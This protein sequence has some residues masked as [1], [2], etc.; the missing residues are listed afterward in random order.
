MSLIRFAED[1]L[2][3]SGLL[4]VDSDYNG[5]AGKAVLE[6]VKTFSEQ[7][8]SGG[9]A[10]LVLSA[11]DKVARFE[12]L[13]PLTYARD[14]W[15]EVTDNIWQNKR[16]ATVFSTDEGKTWY[17]IDEEGRPLHPVE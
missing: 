2:Q 17:D 6:L 7:G 9:S 14:E 11:F 4:D 3:R 10:W 13:T 1:E 8:H 15:V 12:P 16:K 5:E